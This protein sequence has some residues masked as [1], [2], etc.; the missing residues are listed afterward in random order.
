MASDFRVINGPRSSTERFFRIIR[1]TVADSGDYQCVYDS[2]TS[3]IV[4]V[5]VMEIPN[6]G[7]ECIFVV[8]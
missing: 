7:K 6:P 1:L 4:S 8:V 2:I 5:N 3:N